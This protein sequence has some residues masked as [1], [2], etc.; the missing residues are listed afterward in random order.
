MQAKGRRTWV[1][2]EYFWQPGRLVTHGI[3]KEQAAH[4]LRPAWVTALPWNTTAQQ[5]SRLNKGKSIREK[6]HAQRENRWHVFAQLHRGLER[7]SVGTDSRRVFRINDEREN[8]FL[9]P[10]SPTLLTLGSLGCLQSDSQAVWRSPGGPD[11]SLNPDS[12]L[13]WPSDQVVQLE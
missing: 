11:L 6:K 7:S 2:H 12:A 1:L 8:V 13:T 9:K 3:Y 10:P 5:N 4:F